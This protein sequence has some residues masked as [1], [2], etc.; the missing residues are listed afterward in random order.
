MRKSLLF[1]L[2]LIALAYVVVPI[3]VFRFTFLNTHSVLMATWFTSMYTGPMVTGGL[4]I[5]SLAAFFLKMSL[6]E[7]IRQAQ[8]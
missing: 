2:G 7:M 3:L 4:M 8:S 5:V 1:L 6:R